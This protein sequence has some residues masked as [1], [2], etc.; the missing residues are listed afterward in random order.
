VS[1]TSYQVRL[2]SVAEDDL[3]GILAYVTENNRVAAADLLDKFEMCFE[4]LSVNP[5]LGKA[6]QEEPLISLGYRYLVVSN[7][8]V[9]YVVREKTVVIHRVIHGARKYAD[10][11]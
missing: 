6:A 1:K 4:R 7:Y 3:G 5:H 2:L 8:L 11:F 9:F 10:F